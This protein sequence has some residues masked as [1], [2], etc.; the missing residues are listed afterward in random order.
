MPWSC[1]VLSL[2]LPLRTFSNDR[3]TASRTS[4][5]I[6]FT[7][8]SLHPTYHSNIP[9]FIS[10]SLTYLTLSHPPSHLPSHH[11]LP[12]SYPPTHP[13]TL[14]P[15][16]LT[17]SRTAELFGP[18]IKSKESMLMVMVYKPLRCGGVPE[19][20]FSC[21]KVQQFSYVPDV[22]EA[23]ALLADTPDCFNQVRH[24]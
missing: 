16:S 18:W 15:L 19:W 6:P 23:I 24:C 1:N 20:I 11:S 10:H 4:F 13:L 7:H 3:F 12:L 2:S 21:D 8:Y 14:A 9:S 22:A 5:V 17:S